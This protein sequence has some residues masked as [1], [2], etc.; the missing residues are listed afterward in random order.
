M[1]KR[2]PVIVDQTGRKEIYI[3]QD[4]RTINAAQIAIASKH[5]LLT[6]A[7]TASPSVVGGTHSDLAARVYVYGIPKSTNK[8]AKTNYIL[9][10]NKA[11]NLPSSGNSGE[12]MITIH[13]IQFAADDYVG[14]FIEFD[15]S[16]FTVGSTD[17]LGV[18]YTN[19][20][21]VT[22]SYLKNGYKVWV[23]WLST[24]QLEEGTNLN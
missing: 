24:A 2:I 13:D 17:L 18:N 5:K 19:I 22:A 21:P 4:G 20:T 10:S 1:T 23:S 7:G 6:S 3:I 11:L 8:S 12:E 16:P 14:I 15:V 9:L